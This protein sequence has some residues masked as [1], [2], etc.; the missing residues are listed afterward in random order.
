MK[1]RILIEMCCHGRLEKAVMF[2]GRHG[3]VSV[4]MTSFLLKVTLGKGAS[5][6][7]F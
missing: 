2:V 3:N 5:R 7:Y 6:N 1:T 4:G